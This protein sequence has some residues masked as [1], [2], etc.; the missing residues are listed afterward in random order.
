MLN[1]VRVFLSLVLTVSLSVVAT[2]GILVLGAGDN[3]LISERELESKLSPEMPP[4]EVNA[5]LGLTGT[6]LTRISDHEETLLISSAGWLSLLIPQ[7]EVTAVFYD[8]K[9]NRVVL[10]E[11]YG[12]D[13]RERQLALMKK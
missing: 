10:T 11:Y 4:E 6:R 3:Q 8:S 13:E 2:V 7:K 1:Y 12:V 5:R 9:L